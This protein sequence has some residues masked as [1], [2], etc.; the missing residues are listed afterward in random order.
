MWESKPRTPVVLTS[1]VAFAAMTISGCATSAEPGTAGL[2]ADFGVAV[3]HNRNAQF[4]PPTAEQKENTFIRPNAARQR[5]AVETY[6]AGEVEL[7]D[8]ELA[9]SG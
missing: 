4:V 9:T 1:L 7:D 8:S 5:L 6:E 3:A 2:G